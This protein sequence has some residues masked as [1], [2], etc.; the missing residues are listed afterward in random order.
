MWVLVTIPCMV[1][2]YV[3]LYPHHHAHNNSQSMLLWHMHG[4]V[5]E[6]VYCQLGT[7]WSQS[8]HPCSCGQWIQFPVNV[9]TRSQIIPLLIDF[10]W[11]IFESMRSG[12]LSTLPIICGCSW[13][14]LPCLVKA[15]KPQSTSIW[16]LLKRGKQFDMCWCVLIITWGSDPAPW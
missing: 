15:V 12:W 7:G 6:S 4:M 1:S 11:V 16:F 3:W 5:S 10:T 2:K 9:R 8:C 14:P 13:L